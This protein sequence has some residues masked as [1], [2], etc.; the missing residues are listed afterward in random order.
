MSAATQGLPFKVL[1][2]CTGNSARSQMAEGLATHLGEGRVEA[3][4]AGT[5]PVGVNRHAIAVM[6]ER[7]I[8]ISGQYSK[9]LDDVPPP[10]DLVITLCDSAAANCPRWIGAYPYEHWSTPDPSFVEGGTDAVRRAFREVR[11]RLEGQIQDLL[12]RVRPARRP[13]EP[14]DGPPGAPPERPPRGPRGP[15]RS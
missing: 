1:F 10:F 14:H 7:G 11:D 9:G 2:V 15:R 5:I 6:E 12:A 8:D 3:H 4:S 13:G